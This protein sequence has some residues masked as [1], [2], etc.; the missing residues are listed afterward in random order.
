MRPIIAI[1]ANMLRHDGGEF[2]LRD[3]VSHQFGDLIASAGA[4]PVIIPCTE[5]VEAVETVLERADGLL[6]S[7]GPD[8]SPDV[9]GQGPC[10]HLGGVEPLRD[11]VDDIALRYAYAH[12]MPMLG[13]CRGIQSM[14]VYAGGT[15]IQDIPS[16]VPNALQHGQKAPG[17]H[18]IHEITI[19]P[20]SLL[21]RVTGRSRAMVNSFHHQAV[22]TVPEGWVAS[23]RT[24]D[25]VIEAIEKPQSK[26]CLGLQFHPE[27][28]AAR[29]PFAMSIFSSFVA[30]V[31]GNCPYGSPA[32]YNS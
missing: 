2:S 15:L 13:I 31:T 16:Q 26:F 23:A 14:A 32:L 24:A 25:G 7:G 12:D 8:V 27:L 6:V 10:A 11:A 21:A 30:S 20:E 5:D 9:Y 3:V 28:M 1:I 19:E 22:D 4:A 17:F 29:H 18:G